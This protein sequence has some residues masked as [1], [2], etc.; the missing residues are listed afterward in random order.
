VYGELA[1]VPS[2]VDPAKNWTFAIP[3][4]SDADAVNAKD[5]PTWWVPAAGADSETVGGV[6]AATDTDVVFVPVHVL[7]PVAV[8]VFVPVALQ[9][10]VTTCGNVLN[11]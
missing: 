4:A 10:R 3:W 2:N 7:W 6:L 9:V 8:I 5:V 1:S 11:A